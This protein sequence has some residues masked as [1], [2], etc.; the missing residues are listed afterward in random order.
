VFQDV[1]IMSGELRRRQSASLGSLVTESPTSNLL[2]TK[3]R[4]AHSR[5]VCFKSFRKTI[6]V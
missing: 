6:R 3:P 2:P 1:I 5:P 4:G